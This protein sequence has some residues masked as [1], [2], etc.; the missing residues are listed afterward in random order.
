MAHRSRFDGTHQPGPGLAF[1]RAD[2]CGED[3]A[4]GA[5]RDAIY[6]LQ[7][8]RQARRLAA[9]HTDPDVARRLRESAVRHEHMARQLKRQEDRVKGEG[10]ISTSLKILLRTLRGRG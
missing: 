3:R 2:K 1:V 7:L 8:A 4:A 9:E 6:Y 10:R 5:P